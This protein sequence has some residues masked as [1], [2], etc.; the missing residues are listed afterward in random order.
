VG[1]RKPIANKTILIVEDEAILRF[2]LVDFFE[3]AGW[4]VF[5]ATNAESAIELL[6]RHREIGAVLTD[7]NM[8]GS[9]DGLALAHH[10]RRRYP[11]TVLFVV[12]GNVPLDSEDLPVRTAFM[13]KPFDP[14]RLLRELEAASL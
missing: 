5:E 8:P 2:D 11:P 14:H 6:D 1:Q 13:P 3:H 9:M 7:V 4:R 12:S 10:V